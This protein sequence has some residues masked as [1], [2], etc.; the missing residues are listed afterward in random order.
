MVQRFFGRPTFDME[1]QKLYTVVLVYRNDGLGGLIV[2]R[3]NAELTLEPMVLYITVRTVAGRVHNLRGS[4][5]YRFPIRS[6][7][8]LYSTNSESFNIMRVL[9]YTLV[10]DRYSTCAEQ[11]GIDQTLDFM[12]LYEPNAMRSTYTPCDCMYRSNL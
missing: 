7:H 10:P 12:L 8:L 2:G 11:G 6:S 9:Y 3:S 4:Y 1:T 5:S